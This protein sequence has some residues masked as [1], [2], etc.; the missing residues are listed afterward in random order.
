MKFKKTT[1]SR[2]RIVKSVKSET[3]NNFPLIE[4]E[5]GTIVDLYITWNQ[6][7]VR[8]I[9]LN[10]MNPFWKMRLIII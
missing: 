10:I 5:R 6:H 3:N 8:S 9:I 4:G 2:N 1:T 7:G